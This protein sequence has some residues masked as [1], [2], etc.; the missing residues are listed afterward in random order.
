MKKYIFIALAA[1]A[2]LSSCSKES[3]VSN[4]KNG[5][6]A[7]VFT[8]TME[9]DITTKVTFDATNKHALWE[10]GDAISIDGHTYTAEQ[11]GASSTFTGS[12]AT[13][14]THHAYFPAGIYNGGTPTLPAE[15]T[16]AEG[17]FNMPMYAESSDLV[18]SF[19][20]LC[21]VLAI[22]VNKSNLVSTTTTSLKSIKVSSDKRMNGA[23]SATAAGVLSFTSQA[24]LTDTD[25]SVTLTMTDDVDISTDRTFY[26]AI[27]AQ[28]YSY[29]KIYLS[30]DGSTYKEAMITQKA[31]GLGTIAR[32]TMFNI[33]YKTNAVQLY[34][35]GPYWSTMNI[36]A[37]AATDCGT[38]FSWG[39]VENVYSLS[40]TTFTFQTDNPNT[41][42][43]I[44]TWTP[45]NGF[46]DSNAP[47]YNG[48]EYT[49]Y[50]LKGT[51]GEIDNISTLKD[52]DDAATANWGAA[53][54]MPAGGTSGQ[55]TAL[56]NNTENVWTTIGDVNGQKI[57]GKTTYSDISVFFPVTS[58]GNALVINANYTQYGIYW[59]SSL[60][61]NTNYN[62][63][64]LIFYFSSSVIQSTDTNSQNRYIGLPVRPISE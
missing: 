54:K 12:G 44:G 5:K 51:E 38:Y 39:S 37:R 40:G 27:P 22:T 6:E 47:Y 52:D 58:V 3:L 45:G 35:D 1:I 53:W 20:N 31:T 59:S 55:F 9:D 25:K 16:Y 62:K 11:A 26:I 42:R 32:S 64:A 28:D 34:A 19:K 2:T 61:P 41:T 14:S 17:K 46:A 23:F 33:T 36:G 43:Y 30:A 63:M 8:A 21:A 4:D 57:S 48:S 29:L 50:Q 60:K 24:A 10:V 15:Q 56:I 49:K 13:E 18:L 7:Q